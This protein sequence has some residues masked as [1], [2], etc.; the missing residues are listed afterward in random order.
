M[1]LED[2]R[3]DQPL[4]WEHEDGRTGTEVSLVP[5]LG[6]VFFFDHLGP[7]VRVKHCAQVR[8]RVIHKLPMWSEEALPSLCFRV[9]VVRRFDET[10]VNAIPWVHPEVIHCTLK[11]D[12]DGCEP[13]LCAR[14]EERVKTITQLL[15]GQIRAEG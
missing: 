13:W 10:F 2:L 7:V 9:T 1:G 8:W 11:A 4:R 14:V 5:K 3:L 12:H 15:Y 6:E